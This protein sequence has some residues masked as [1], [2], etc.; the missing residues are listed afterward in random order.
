MP[1]IGLIF[2]DMN[3]GSLSINLKYVKNNSIIPEDAPEANIKS[4]E[5]S[6]GYRKTLKYSIPWLSN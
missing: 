4:Y 6:I 1:T 3:K 5:V 2:S